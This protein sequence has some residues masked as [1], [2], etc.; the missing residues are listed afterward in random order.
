MS[1][2]KDEFADLFSSVSSA[3][4][5]D[6]SRL[7]MAERQQLKSHNNST[8]NLSNN[9]RSNN[10]S[11]VS[12]NHWDDIGFLNR[13]SNTPQP[14]SSNSTV[15]SISKNPNDLFEGFDIL[16]SSLNSKIPKEQLLDQTPLMKTEN[17]FEG[18]PS[19]LPA[20]T[21]NVNEHQE[22]DLLND[23]N[24]PS[25]P[26]TFNTQGRAPD[27]SAQDFDDLFAVFN[28]PIP[29][30]NII[31]NPV[32]VHSSQRPA[33]LNQESPRNSSKPSSNQYSR[34]SS[35]NTNKS[36]H[37]TSVIN[38]YAKDE[39]VAHLIDMGFSIEQSTE[40]LN[41]TSNGLNVQEAIS[42]IMNKAHNE[43][44]LKQGL[45]PTAPSQSSQRYHSTESPYLQ[46][47]SSLVSKT[48]N[49]LAND[50]SK[51]IFSP[52]P[53]NDGRPAWMRDQAKYKAR[54][55]KQYDKDPEGLSEE[56][57]SKLKLKEKQPI[58]Q[59]E[60]KTRPLPKQYLSSHQNSFQEAL[61]QPKPEQEQARSQ[62]QPQSQP[63]LE[64]KVDLF[65]PLSTSNP[66]QSVSEP[67]PEVDLFS[68]APSLNSNRLRKA[69][70]RS[71][72][73]T[74]SYPSSSDRSDIPISQTQLAFFNDSRKQGGACFKNGDF[75][76]ALTHYESSLNSLPESHILR[77]LA[78]SNCITTLIKVG[79][80]KKVLEYSQFALNIIG[81]NRGA[82][83]EVERGKPMK[84]FWIKINQKK[85]EALEHLEKFNDSL[86]VW[87]ELIEN[88]SANK[89]SLDGKRRCQ[90]ALNPKPKS[91]ST[92]PASSSS[93]I[94][95][96]NTAPNSVQSATIKPIGEVLKRVRETQKATEAFEQDKFK[97]H[98]AVEARIN[99]WKTGKED[100][101]RALLASLHEI[102]WDS[103]NWRQIGLSDLVIPKKVKILYMKA[104][105]KTHPDKI[106]KD[107]TSEQKL[108]AQ[109]VF[110][111][112]NTAWEA[113]KTQ[114]NIQ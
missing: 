67:Q 61:Q 65:S 92:P 98:D 60:T 95:Q 35:S 58:S 17:L 14:T 57:L 2:Q 108:I 23:F 96:A 70:S 34:A 72:T 74:K 43:A 31:E 88:G 69:S 30:K 26:S 6:D 100:N 29:S 28:N 40:A 97:L 10:G 63:Q 106:P 110:V 99:S 51:R 75:S 79:E 64:P 13:P 109:N 84:D 18:F 8:A 22:I 5:N 86:A 44:R 46:S 16:N 114:N 11:R 83:E 45:P 15:S 104:V 68:P 56:T 102:L 42:F 112:I 91:R 39:A 49:K 36:Q 12:N 89:I 19:H 48:T 59:Q 1:F 24:L 25:H 50:L 80:N 93:S 87:T 105:A 94:K 9:S 33:V 82:D 77:I 38:N 81:P 53:A 71:G 73:G 62:P 103:S 107:A 90:E 27:N 66:L 21:P 111:V 113:F 78:Y 20:Q 54:S 4:R 76:T 52:A 41:H 85:A 3:K 47:F 7:S 55:V 32:P 101:L 37:K